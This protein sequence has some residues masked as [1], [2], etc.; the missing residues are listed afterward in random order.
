[1]DFTPSITVLNSINKGIHC[2][3]ME[4]AG[5]ITKDASKKG[6]KRKDQDGA[7]PGDGSETMAKTM[8]TWTDQLTEGLIECYEIVSTR[9]ECVTEAKK[10]LKNK[11]W[12]IVNEMMGQVSDSCTFH[13]EVLLMPSSDCR[14]SQNINGLSLSTSRSK[15]FVLSRNF[16]LSKS[17][18]NL[19]CGAKGQE[20]DY[21]LSPTTWTGRPISRGL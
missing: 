12:L 6:S 5:K 17:P 10:N 8:L 13:R 9:K 4:K 14:N 20:L 2:S 21:H 19:S 18:S 16:E 3:E 15:T 1:M 11:G 7:A